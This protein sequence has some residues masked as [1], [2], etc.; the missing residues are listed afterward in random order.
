VDIAVVD[1]TTGCSPTTTASDCTLPITLLNINVVPGPGASVAN[2]IVAGNT[3]A[4][5]PDAAGVFTDLGGNLIGTAGSTAGNTGFSASTLLGSLGT[6]LLP[7]LYPLGNYGGLT[8]TLLPM[9]GSPVIGAGLLANANGLSS[10]QRDFPRTVNGQVDIGADEFQGV[11]LTATGGTPQSAAVGAEFT[12]PLEVNAVENLSS[13]PLTGATVNFSAP[14]SGAS[15]VLTTPSPTT[16]SNGNASTTATANGTL[17]GYNVTAS[18]AAGSAQFALTNVKSSPTITTTPNTTSVTLGT[19]STTLKDSATLAG[20]SSPTG[21]ITFTLYL[22]SSLLDTETVAVN[23]N[24]TYTTPTGYTLPTSGTVAGTYQWNAAYTGDSNNH[25]VSENNNSSEQVAV[26]P[27]PASKPLIQPPELFFG[28]QAVDTSSPAEFVVL[29]GT[30]RTNLNFSSIT[31]TGTNAGDFA[32]TNHCGSSLEPEHTCTL[33]V[34]FRPSETG[35]RETAAISIADNA[36]NSPQTVPLAGTGVVQAQVAPSSVTFGAQKV[37][38]TSGPRE[39]TLTNNLPTGLEIDSIT[40]TGADH[41]D[42]AETNTCGTRL[43]PQSQCTIFVTFRPEATGARSATLEVN[44]SG[45]NTPQTV[46]LGGT[47]D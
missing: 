18:L 2:T 35:V 44:D 40:F 19:T 3:A 7:Q 25:S 5:D 26:N 14:A 10:D 46:A 16:D 28:N 43:G 17:G 42:F 21:T 15:A 12:A 31:I 24:G 47:G 11:A 13:V 36:G 9:V 1:L 38:T 6:S 34:T 23:G 8:Q 32:L 39:V 29:V 20:G 4:N 37:K 27:A 41:G 30:G 22:G 45:N 33:D